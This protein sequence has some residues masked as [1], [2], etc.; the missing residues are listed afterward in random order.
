MARRETLLVTFYTIIRY[1]VLLY[2]MA[3]IWE[4][5]WI[6][7]MALDGTSIKIKEKEVH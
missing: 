5:K 3:C 1:T 6:S 4:T 2:G 7:V